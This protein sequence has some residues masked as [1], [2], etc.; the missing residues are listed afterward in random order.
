MLCFK[1]T[2]TT[3]IGVRPEADITQIIFIDMK[4]FKPQFILPAFALFILSC[5]G[6]ENTKYDAAEST[7]TVPASTNQAQPL[8]TQ[9]QTGTPAQTVAL[10]PPHGEPNH[11][12][13]IQVGAPLNSPATPSLRPVTPSFNP[14]QGAV[15]PGTNPPHGQPGHDCAVAVGAPLNK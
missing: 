5:S 15:A 3:A 13:D 14:A 6:G 12:C 2:T 1:G 11:R 10:N 4:K 8:N 9:T 7:A